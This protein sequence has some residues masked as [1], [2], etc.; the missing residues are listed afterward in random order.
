MPSANAGTS[1]ATPVADRI[2]ALYH[3]ITWKLIPFLCFCYLAS[4]L[5]RINIG[6]AKL[7]MLQDLHFSETAFGL[8]RACFSSVISCS[9]CRAT[10]SWRK[11]GPRSGLPGS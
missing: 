9:R 1:L 4:Y 3:K 11:S 8:G 10:W 7:Q 6:F 5:D 2:K